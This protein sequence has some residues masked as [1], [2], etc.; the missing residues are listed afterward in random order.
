MKENIKHLDNELKNIKII[1]KK[2]RQIRKSQNL[3][4]A[5]LAE[6]VGISDNY[7]GKIERGEIIPSLPVIIKIANILKIGVD[8]LLDENLLVNFEKPSFFKEEISKKI[9]TL[10]LEQSKYIYNLLNSLE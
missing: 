10:N 9:P 4:I 5:A 8:Y 3:S 7:Q 2:I 6:K 1:G